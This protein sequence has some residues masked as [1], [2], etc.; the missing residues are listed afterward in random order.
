[1]YLNRRSTKSNLLGIKQEATIPTKII[2]QESALKRINS[3]KRRGAR[4]RTRLSLAALIVAFLS[5]QTTL[6]DDGSSQFCWIIFAS[7][8][9]APSSSARPQPLVGTSVQLS[10]DVVLGNNNKSN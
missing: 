4:L 9:S 2:M 8:A 6:I 1:M 10:D 3:D 7:A 5:L